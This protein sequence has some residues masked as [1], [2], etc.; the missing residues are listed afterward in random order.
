MLQKPDNCI[1]VIFGASGD[2]TRRKLIPGLF[3]LYRRNLMPESF[4]VFGASRTDWSDQQFSDRMAEGLKEFSDLEDSDQEKAKDFI[5]RL[6]YHTLDGKDPDNDYTALKERLGSLSDK[7]QIG[8]NY[9]FYLSTPPSAFST[10]T[11]QLKKQGLHAEKPENGWRRLI[12]EKPFGYDLGSALKLNKSL[13]ESFKEEQIYRIDHYLGKE[14]VQNMLVFRFANGIF[15]PLW[16]RNYVDRVEITSAESI[17]VGSRGGYYDGSGA[18]R[19]MFQNHLLQ[20]FGMV[21]MEPP[22]TFN[23]DSV[24]N[25]TIKVFESMRPLKLEDVP[26]QVVRGQYTASVVKGESVDGYRDEDGVP[27]D[28]LTETYVAVKF[29]VDNWRWAGVPFLI[30]T[31][32]RLPTRVT[33]V[34][35]HFKQ[36]PHHLFGSYNPVA[37]ECNKLI[38]RIQPDEGI[39]MKINMKLP[40]GGFKVKTVNMDF[41]YDDLA[42]VYV[43]QAYERLLLDCML[44][45]ATLYAR[46]DAVEACWQ[47]VDPIQ[48]AWAENP[49]IKIYGYPGGTW[50]PKEARALFDNPALDWRYP[51]KNLAS[52]GEYC[53]L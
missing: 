10:I 6:Y 32:K 38:I 3:N 9:L 16:N 48:R 46:G 43:P 51:C 26:K 23:A 24:R 39:L 50:G 12:V 45:D 44:G 36:T 37:S 5:S 35:I 21:A 11:R 31:G 41:H 2:L 40:G 49:D 1:L 7:N 25:E 47:F 4:L 28:S 30:R 17:G 42:N 33:E 53:E 34:V 27:A 13:H 52:D 29:F 8:G 19:D 20:V 22:G 15:E 18:L 14:T